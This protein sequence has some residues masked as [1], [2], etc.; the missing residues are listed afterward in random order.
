MKNRNEKTAEAELCECRKN[1]SRAVRQWEL[2][3]ESGCS[4]PNWTDGCNLNLVRNHVL[5]FKKRAAEICEETGAPLPE[6]CFF[7]T[8]PEA[9]SSY[10]ASLN[11]KNR[12]ERLACS[13]Q[14]LTT[15]RI[16]FDS[17]QLSFA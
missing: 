15:K 2:I 14:E 1:I 6:E 16:G 17:R 8:P 5:Y 11:Q 13:G 7:P 10:M 9:D 3:N 4:D 12:V